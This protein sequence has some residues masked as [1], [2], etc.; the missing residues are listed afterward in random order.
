MIVANKAFMNGFVSDRTDTKQSL[1]QFFKL[2]HNSK[3]LIQKA[4]RN[5]WLF[6][7]LNLPVGKNVPL[8]YMNLILS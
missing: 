7:V 2:R 8:V 5:S 6:A 3:L 4:M 1:A